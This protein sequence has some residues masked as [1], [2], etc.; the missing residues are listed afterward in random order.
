[1]GVLCFGGSGLNHKRGYKEC[2]GA[3][4]TD[5]DFDDGYAA[6]GDQSEH[7][8]VGIVTPTSFDAGYKQLSAG[9]SVY[10]FAEF[11]KVT[12][13]NNVDYELVGLSL[14]GDGADGRIV[15]ENNT[16]R[17]GVR[18]YKGGSVVGTAWSGYNLDGARHELELR[19]TWDESGATDK[20]TLELRVDGSGKVTHQ[21]TGVVAASNWRV[22]GFN[23][24]V[25][26]K[27]A[28]DG[29]SAMRVGNMFMHDGM[30]SY[31]NSWPR[32]VGSDGPHIAW[33]LANENIGTPDPPGAPAAGE[34]HYGWV[35]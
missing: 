12:T 15:M 32:N 6:E 1:M 16:H 26:Y 21:F 13:E 27:T 23:A 14:R 5:N 17:L 4:V 29:V 18:L 35:Y 3:L 9:I 30:G 20:W 22:G 33:G 28:K 25:L 2:L 11:K 8:G 34:K 19:Q 7:T 10:M 31:A 24:G